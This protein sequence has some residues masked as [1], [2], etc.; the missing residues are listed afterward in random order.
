MQG[1]GMS[2]ESLDEKLWKAVIMQAINDAT[3]KVATMQ[4]EKQIAH[5][6]LMVPNRDFYAV[7]EL[8]NLQPR[9]VRAAAQKLIAERKDRVPNHSGGREK[10]LLTLNGLTLSVGE[11]SK[12][13]GFHPG[14]I[15]H[16]LRKGWSIERALTTP[17][18]Q[19][20]KKGAGVVRDFNKAPGTGGGSTVRE[21]AE[22]EYLAPAKELEPCP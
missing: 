13:C 19:R 5:D 2:K 8:A 17:L 21:R 22:I 4:R 6:W 7:C 15:R 10:Q 14:T 1:S 9:D 18:S 3:S 16:R 20:P 12:R 11:W